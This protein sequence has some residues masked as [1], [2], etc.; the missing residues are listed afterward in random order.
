[1]KMLMEKKTHVKNSVNRLVFCGLAVL[2]QI[3]FFVGMGFALS[4]YSTSIMLM[5]QVIALFIGF[6]VYGRTE[7][8][9]FKLPWIFL[10]LGFPILGISIFLLFGNKQLPR[11]I[12][13]RFAAID[14]ALGEKITEDPTVTGRL[15]EQN[16]Y[17]A[18]QCRYI[19]NRGAFPVFSNTDITF[20][21][22]AWQGFEAQLRDLEKAESFIFLEYHA[23]EEAQS[24][25]RLQAILAEKARAGV[26]VRILY[27]DI[28]SIGF[29]D[30]GFIGRMKKI[31]VACRV[32]NSV[33]PFLNLFMNNRDHRK[34]T[35]IDGKVGFTGGYNLADEYFNLKHPYGYWKDTGVRLEGDAVKSLTG[36]FLE[37]WNAM[38]DTDDQFERYLPIYPYTS[39]EN[40]FVQPYADR[41][42]DNEPLSENVYL[43]MI[44]S[45]TDKLYVTTPYLIISDEMNRE[46]CLAAL[47]GVDVRIVT[48][49]IPDK[50]MIYRVTRSYYAGLVR[51]GVRIFEYT[52]GFIHAKQMLCDNTLA[53]VG[54][55]NL[56]YRS[57]YHHFENGVLFTGYRAVGE[58]AADFEDLFRVSTDVSEKYRT[59][60]TSLRLSQCVLRLLAPLL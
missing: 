30:P 17:I 29:I 53:A 52:P 10:I 7:V 46:L 5:F 33:V 18:N 20:Y 31:G 47:R 51:H 22:E 34:I 43:N 4:V 36:M 57:L 12:R 2:L 38:G 58:V 27:D 21:P 11:K 60:K 19:A 25:A 26:E 49:G 6:K 15:R 40:G 8:S 39:S 24:F 45:A 50:K 41:P 3:L 14:S 44:K 23:I 9:T 35:V 16:P 55:I 1:M 54:T 42:M 13:R 48:P 56:D 37:M 28:G 59:K 32:F